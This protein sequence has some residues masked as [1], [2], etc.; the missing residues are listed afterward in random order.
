MVQA[1][2]RCDDNMQKDAMFRCYYYMHIDGL[3]HHR[4]C[5]FQIKET[6]QGQWLLG[7]A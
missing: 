3:L 5:D 1:M 6:I 4:K 7:I 2:F